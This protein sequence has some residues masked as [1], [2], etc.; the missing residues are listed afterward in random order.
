MISNDPSTAQ[1]PKQRRNDLDWIRVLAVIALLF[2]HTG[3]LFVAEWD[4][5]I[6]NEQR[7]NL[8]LEWMHFMSGWRMS[9]LFF[10]SGAGTY[11]ALGLRSPRAYLRERGARL[12]IPLAFGMAV[13]T[14]PQVYFERLFRGEIS[15]GYFDF[16]PASLLTGPYPDG[17]LTWNHLWFV[18][19]LFLFSVIA[20]PLFRALRGG[21][22]QG[23]NRFA[24]R[25]PLLLTGITGVLFASVYALLTIPFPGPQN[26]INDW[27]RFCSYLILFVFGFLSLSHRGFGD[28]WFRSRRRALQAGF[29]MALV[30]YALRW[31]QIDWDWGMN[32]AS[33]AYMMLRGLTGFAFTVAILGYARQYLTSGGPRLRYANEAV[34]PFYILHQSVIIIVGYYVIQTNDTIL[35]KFLFVAG[36]SFVLSIGI[37]ELFIRNNPL[38]RL[39]FGVKRRSSAARVA[40]R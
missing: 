6:Q 16:W 28:A 17:N 37:Y 11:F 36:V 13:I 32:P 33:I 40:Q 3:M 15:A 27:G 1:G 31:N 22:W 18:L 9:L 5:H 23:L 10:V 8:F 19:Y 24:E 20:L 34:Y 25:N 12:L 21:A 14:P 26:L 2:F 35:T 39:L 30:L 29:L 38:L 7:S 4:W